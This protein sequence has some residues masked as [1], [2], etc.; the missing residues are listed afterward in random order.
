M[1]INTLNAIN[2][3]IDKIGKDKITPAAFELLLKQMDTEESEENIKEAEP[4]KSHKTAGKATR[5]LEPDEYEKIM[6][7]LNNGFIYEDSH[8]KIRKVKPQPNVALAL[9]L[10]ASLGLRISDI[11]KLK[12]KH[13]QKNKLELHEKKTNKLQYREMDPEISLYIKDYALQ[14]GL[15]MEDYLINVKTRWIQDRLHKACIYLGLTNV[16]THSFRKFFAT[17]IYKISNG[18]IDLL[19]CL[20]NHSS[21]V[22]TQDYLQTNQS[23]IDEFSRSVNFLVKKQ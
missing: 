12:V 19:K 10:E 7:L 14:N 4:R 17:Y 8:G 15:Q 21:V 5:P 20:L 22:V 2:S 23:R 16:S 3:I 6:S 9:S 1:S 11:L 13:F 18:D